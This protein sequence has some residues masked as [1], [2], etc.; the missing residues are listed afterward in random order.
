MQTAAWWTCLDV[1]GSYALLGRTRNWLTS[2]RVRGCHFPAG[3]PEGRPWALLL[4]G[5][6]HEPGV[7][8]NTNDTR[9]GSQRCWWAPIWR[10]DF[11]SPR[12]W[13]KASGSFEKKRRFCFSDVYTSFGI[14]D[15]YSEMW[16]GL[17]VSVTILE[18]SCGVFGKRD[19]TVLNNLSRRLAPTRLKLPVVHFILL[20]LLPV[21]PEVCWVLASLTYIQWLLSCH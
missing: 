20:A 5:D 9:A 13:N 7:S 11:F 12:V 10:Q 3:R 15:E 14:F 4:K 6:S 18:N 19:W 1:P 17:Y 16:N 21:S 8:W 2:G